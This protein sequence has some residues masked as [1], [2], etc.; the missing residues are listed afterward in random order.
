M[1][2]LAHYKNQNRMK[3]GA[4][5]TRETEWLFW[6][7]VGEIFHNNSPAVYNIDWRLR[8]LLDSA[9]CKNV[10]HVK[11]GWNGSHRYWDLYSSADSKRAIRRV[12]E[13]NNKNGDFQKISI[14]NPYRG[15]RV[16]KVPNGVRERVKQYATDG[17]SERKIADMT[18]L[19]RKQV[20]YI[21]G[22]SGL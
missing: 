18:G 12:Y 6:E 16:S 3:G 4:I 17:C 20:R 19:S 11:R 1:V 8:L 5:L 14:A 2:L 7:L 22:R 13:P 21:L 9:G 15:G 10:C